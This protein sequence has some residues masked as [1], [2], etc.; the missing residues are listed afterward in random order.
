MTTSYTTAFWSW[1][2]WELQLDWMALRGINLPLAWVGV[3]KILIDVFREVG[4]TDEEILSFIS[5]PAF[6]AWNHMG[7]IQ[8]SWGGDMPLEWVDAQFE[9]QKKI[10][11]RMVELGM[12]PILPAF[13]GFVP[14]AITRLFPDATVVNGSQW[15]DF[16]PEYTNVTFLY[17]TDERFVE[18]QQRFIQKQ[19][20]AYGNVTHYYALDQFNEN[21]PFSGDL[22]DLK[23]ISKETWD[24]L[25]KSDPAAVW[26]LQGWLFHSNRDF[27]SNERIELY[28]S[29]VPDS[30]MIVLDLFSESQPQWQRTES[31]FGKPWIWC[32]LHNFGGNMGLYGQ[33]LN[34]TI[35]PVEAVH[36]SD[37]L[38]GF[39]LTM[40]GQEGN[41]IVYDLLLDQ[42]WSDTPIDTWYYFRHWVTTRYAGTEFIPY[43]L[44][45]AW[46][47][48]RTTVYNNTNLT[49][50]AVTKSIFELVPRTSGLVNRTGHHPTTIN[51][52]QADL[53]QAWSNFFAAVDREPAL[54]ENP[55]FNYDL[56]D[57]T[58]Q[59]LSNAFVPEYESLIKIYQDTA[60]S[61]PRDRKRKLKAAGERLTSLLTALDAVLSTNP[62]FRL[63]TWI[64]AAR[65]TAPASSSA[66]VADFLEYEARNQITLWG[67]TGQIS[68]YSSRA[69]SG[70]VSSYYIPRWQKFVNYLIATEPDKYNQSQFEEDL[71]RW[72]IKWQKQK[73][74][75][76]EEEKDTKTVLEEVLKTHGKIFGQ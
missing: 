57:I 71:L 20:E 51:Y 58:R 30:D 70:L 8:G 74:M 33:I 49:S 22:D 2:D 61:K 4:F 32:Q 37:S 21:D 11:R 29:G 65:A 41:E 67:P 31:Y 10:V 73:L 36:E 76:A 55:A 18:L 53:V 48:L 60:K 6:L 15:N 47:I 16:P 59:V 43:E 69:W 52:D 35:N 5:G 9:L 23:S 7:N 54:W 44:Y 38:V 28:L 45:Q 34:L 62:H 24:S 17:P 25:K 39:G 14:R 72:E 64:R 13:T 75:K 26:V 63:A 40:E 3:E 27:W 56:V 19:F 68:D 46:D 50:H 66:K 1:E 42:A 12:T